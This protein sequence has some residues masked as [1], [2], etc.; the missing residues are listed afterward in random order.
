[1]G[2]GC[3]THRA[4]REAIFAIP[5]A[6]NVTTRQK[7]DVALKVEKQ[8]CFQM[9]ATALADTYIDRLKLQPHPKN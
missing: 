5:T 6:T 1:M 8:N 2:D 7:N 4:F 3:S 9:F